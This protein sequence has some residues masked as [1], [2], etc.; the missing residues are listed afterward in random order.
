MKTPF[1]GGCMCGAIRY[2][3]SAEPIAMGLCHCQDCQRATG[4]AFAAAV[5]LPRS[6]VLVS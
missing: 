1:T 3:C 5:M 6:A 4:S 2:E